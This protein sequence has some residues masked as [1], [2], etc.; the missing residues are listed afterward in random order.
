MQ[1]K[2][3]IKLH[4]IYTFVHT[5]YL[6]EF[7]NR[8]NLQ[9]YILY[10][11]LLVYTNNYSAKCSLFIKGGK[12]LPKRQLYFQETPCRVNSDTCLEGPYKTT[13]T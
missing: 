7:V 4:A 1:I 3:T 13:K 12:L 5:K 10:V 11:H 6:T 2:C 9:C 8:G